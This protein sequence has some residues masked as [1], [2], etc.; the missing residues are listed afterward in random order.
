MGA[1]DD[2]TDAGITRFADV[3]PAQLAQAVAHQ[4][5]HM[6]AV[7]QLFIL[8]IFCAGVGGAA[9]YKQALALFLAVRQVGADGIQAHIG[10]QR[11]DISLKV[12][13]KVCL[14]VH[15][16][17]FGNIAALDIGNDRQ[18]GGAHHLQGFGV[19]AHAI[20]TKGFIISDL[21]LVAA[22]GSL[23]GFNNAAVEF[24]HIFTG[25]LGVVHHI[26]GQVAEL[27]IQTHAH[28][29]VGCHAGIQFIHVGHC[30]SSVFCIKKAR[31]NFSAGYC[32]SFW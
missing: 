23:G 10:G 13:G 25:S 8:K 32:L 17:G 22:C 3:I 21:N 9:Q 16:G 2:Q 15:L 11:D 19:S 20:Q 12:A 4:V 27:G 24:H 26:G 14:G 29:A 5:V 31:S 30:C 6:A 18:A 28:R 1:A 7:L